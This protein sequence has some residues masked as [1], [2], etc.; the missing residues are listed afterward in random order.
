LEN[1]TFSVGDRQR[2]VALRESGHSAGVRNR[3]DFFAPIGFRADFFEK[4]L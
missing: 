4:V 2:A 1:F 3:A